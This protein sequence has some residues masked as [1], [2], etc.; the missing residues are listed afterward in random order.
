MSKILVFAESANG[1]LKKST[2]EL[3]TAART[4]GGDVHVLSLGEGSEGLASQLAGWNVK[5]FHASADA[6]LNSY[7]P[8]LYTHVVSEVLNQLKP[9]VILASASMLAKDLFPRVATKTN[10]GV[11]SDC[12]GLKI[13][14]GDITATK[15]LYSGKCT[16]NVEFQN[17]ETKIVL[18]RANQLPVAAPDSSAA[19]AL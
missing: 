4:A 18:M 19:P 15:P 7:N 6:T 11:A 3:L 13:S 10:A 8:E 17:C 1:K 2:L 12:T 16:A 5:E 9:S 14:G